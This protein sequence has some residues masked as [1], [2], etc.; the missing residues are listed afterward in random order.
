MTW[1]RLYYGKPYLYLYNSDK[2]RT[3]MLTKQAA[4]TDWHCSKDSHVDLAQTELKWPAFGCSYTNIIS[5]QSKTLFY[6]A[7]LC[8]SPPQAQPHSPWS[9]GRRCSCQ[10]CCHSRPHCGRDRAPGSPRHS[11]PRDTSRCSRAQPSQPCSCTPQ[12]EDGS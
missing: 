7:A 2:L 9:L 1:L 5:N 8:E 6:F 4:V 11:S 3:V 12:T 10:W